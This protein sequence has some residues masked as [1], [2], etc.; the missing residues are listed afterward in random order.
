MTNT[1]SGLFVLGALVVVVAAIAAF[2]V[3]GGGDDDSDANT[4]ANNVAEAASDAAAADTASDSAPAAIPGLRDAPA[5]VDGDFVED[6]PALVGATGRPQVVEFYTHW[7]SVCRRIKPDVHTVEAEYWGRVDFVY[8]DREADA[9][10]PVV[11][12]FG[13]FG[14][15]VLIL[16]DADGNEVQR[17]F[18]AMRGDELRAALDAFLS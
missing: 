4:T 10:E 18:G 3:L 5:P 7:C 1:R 16:L 13:I 8:L 11:E 15:P 12:Q 6:S 17:W 14:Q 9:N 2:A